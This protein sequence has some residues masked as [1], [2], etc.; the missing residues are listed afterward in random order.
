VPSGTAG[1]LDQQQRRG[2]PRP[3]ASDSMPTEQCAAVVTLSR[4]IHQAG[5]CLAAKKPAASRDRIR[6][7]DTIRMSRRLGDDPWPTYHDNRSWQGGEDPHGDRAAAHRA[8]GCELKCRAIDRLGAGKTARL[9]EFVPPLTRL[10][11]IT[12][13][14]PS[15]TPAPPMTTINFAPL[16]RQSMPRCDP[17]PKPLNFIFAS[18]RGPAEPPIPVTN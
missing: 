12:A 16:A 5:G 14:P 7:P 4:A 6:R 17:F 15:T 1:R 3:S 8:A 10:A 11:P 9:D 18:N 2:R 13:P